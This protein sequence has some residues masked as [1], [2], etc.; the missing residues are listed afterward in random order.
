SVGLE[1]LAFCSDKEYS[2]EISVISVVI[3]VGDVILLMLL[4]LNRRGSPEVG[5]NF[6]SKILRPLSL[7]NLLDRFASLLPIPSRVTRFWR[8][9]F[10]QNN[11]FEEVFLHQ[12]SLSLG[13]NMAHHP[14]QFINCSGYWW[15]ILSIYS[16][17]LW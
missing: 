6:I 17:F 9:R 2:L 13:R 8:F 1:G 10:V 12:S 5:M 11:S 3:G 15:T 16:H 14:M 4:C 7:S